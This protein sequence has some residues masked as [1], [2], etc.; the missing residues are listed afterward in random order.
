MSASPNRLVITDQG[1]SSIVVSGE[2]DAHSAPALAERLNCCSAVDVDIV[3]DMSA[4]TF[5]DSSGLRVLI[6][7]HQRT[8]DAPHG[9]VLRAPSA[10][11][12]RLLEVAGLADHFTLVG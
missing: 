4:V 2:I 11:V 1:P 9:L 3:V 6:D 5:M 10:S 12:V 7:V 8:A